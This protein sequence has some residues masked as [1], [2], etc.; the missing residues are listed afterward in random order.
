MSDWVDFLVMAGAF[1]LVAAG[2]ALWLFFLRRPRRRRKYRP[3]R[4]HSAPVTLA[5]TGGLP[6][7]RPPEPSPAPSRQPADS[8][9][10]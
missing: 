5:Q 2:S 10:S 4:R 9:A 8:D 6:P 7:V 3:H 1:L